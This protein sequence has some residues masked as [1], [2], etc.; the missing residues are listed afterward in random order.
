MIADTLVDDYDVTDL[1][2]RLTLACVELLG[3][4]TAGLMLADQAGRLQL[5]ASSSNTMRT[6]ETFEVANDQ[7][8]CMECF[9]TQRA[10]SAD[11]RED[12]ALLRW[13]LFTIQAR[14][15]GVTG[16]QA[17]PMRLRRQTIGALN[18]FHTAHPWLGEHDIALAQ[19]LADVATIA[20]LQRRALAGSELL[21]EQLQEALNGRVVIEQ[22]KGLLAE[23]GQ[24][25]VDTAF[26]LLRRFCRSGQLQLTETSRALVTGTRDPDDVL[27]LR[28]PKSP[29]N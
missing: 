20:L 9:A 3:T 13:P 23:R 17:L 28:W 14:Q 10:I 15:A 12:A 16:V 27:A 29:N 8:P 26:D 11:L 21:T 24:L 19:A 22:A 6:L 5:V 18:I 25:D 7:G 4:D 1:F 2:D